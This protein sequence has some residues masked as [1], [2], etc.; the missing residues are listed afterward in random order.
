MK[1]QEG[2]LGLREEAMY[3]GE[4]KGRGGFSPLQSS[5]GPVG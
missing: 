1:V 3:P 4:T 5:P 2:G